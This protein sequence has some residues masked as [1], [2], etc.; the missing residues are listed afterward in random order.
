MLEEK[1]LCS[2]KHQLRVTWGSSYRKQLPFLQCRKNKDG[3][4]SIKKKIVIMFNEDFRIS[5]NQEV[6]DKAKNKEI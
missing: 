2:R 1:L 4:N 3:G 5:R 6:N